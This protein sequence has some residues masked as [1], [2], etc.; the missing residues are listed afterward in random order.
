[1]A[2]E[3]R[4]IDRLQVFQ[5]RGGLHRPRRAL[6]SGRLAIGFT[7]GSITDPR[8]G[9]TWP[10]P[11]I[12]WFV[13]RFPQ[14]RISV[15]NAAIGATGSELAVF[16]AQRELIDRGCDIVF[17]E[18]AVNDNGEPAEKRMRTR[19]GLIR[20]LLAEERDVVLAYVYGQGFYDDMLR[21]VVPPSMRVCLMSMSSPVRQRRLHIL[22][23]LAVDRLEG[24]LGLVERELAGGYSAEVDPPATS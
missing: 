3:I 15:E 9:Y 16:R 11:V 1:M 4:P 2:V 12:A 13:E 17:I 20:K 19:E 24:E 23:R 7:G 22:A 14:A 21:G 10:E 5:H 8:P 18:F 6:D